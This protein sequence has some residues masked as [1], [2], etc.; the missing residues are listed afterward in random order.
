MLDEVEHIQAIEGAWGFLRS[1]FSRLLEGDHHFFVT[2]CGKLGLFKNIKEIF[3]H[4]E[5]F[6]FPREIGL[7]APDETIEVIEKP[8][9]KNGIAITDE[10]KKLLVDYTDGH[11]FVIQVFGFYLFELGKNK[12]DKRTFLKEL[13]NIL[14]RLKVQVFKDRFSLASPKERKILEFMAQSDKDSFKPAEIMESL[15]M[16]H[17]RLFLKRLVEKGCLNRVSRGEYTLFHKLFRLYI[18]NEA[19]SS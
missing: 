15:K 14:E 12:I 19:K 13:P 16:K 8:M 7:M 9:M 4:M 5:R 17:G 11:P 10:V 18:Q 2:V 6:F 1:V 3:S